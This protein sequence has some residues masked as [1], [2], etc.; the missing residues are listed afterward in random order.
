MNDEGARAAKGFVGLFFATLF[1]YITFYGGCMACRRKGGPWAITQDKLSDGTPILKIEHHRLLSNG[2]VILRFPGETAPARFT[3][4]PFL[5]IYT[6]P[7]TNALPYGPV[8]F[9]DTTFLPGNVTLDVFGHLVEIIPRTLYVDG[10]DV[11][12]NPGTN[13]VLSPAAKLPIEVRPKLK[14]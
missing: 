1:L 2:P 11:G 8:V 9:L 7:N 10:H 13:I 14:H 12:W 6:Q 3:N 4:H 5:R